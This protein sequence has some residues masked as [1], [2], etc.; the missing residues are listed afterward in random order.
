MQN[1]EQKVKEINNQKVLKQT[2]KFNDTKLKSFEKK[3]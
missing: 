3:T 2:S 1:S